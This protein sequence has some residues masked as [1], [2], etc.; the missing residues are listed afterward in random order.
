MVYNSLLYLLLRKQTWARLFTPKDIH[1]ALQTMHP[2]KALGPEGF[3]AKCFQ[4]QWEK[5]GPSI[6][7]M[8]LDC[9]NKGHSIHILNNTYITLIPKIKNPESM[10]DF[11][12]VSLCNVV[13][14]LLSKA[15]VNRIKP[16]LEYLIGD[17]Q[18]AFVSNRLITNNITIATEVFHWL[19]LGNGKKGSDAY[20]VKIDMRKAY[21][22]LEWRCINWILRRM[23]FPDT[24]IDL[25]MMCVTS[26]RFQV[27]VNGIPSTQFIPSLLEINLLEIT[28]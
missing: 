5:V 17:G 28:N 6:S 25:I 22:R 4:T 15:L 14:K 11:R 23:N 27:L 7:S 1:H 26:V 19:S 16:F 20:V 13:Y 9:L 3:Q 21:D 18:S 24:I 12:H 10:V 2:I 8:L